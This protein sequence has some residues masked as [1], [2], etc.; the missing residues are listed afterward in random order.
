VAVVAPVE[1]LQAVGSGGWKRSIPL[2]ESPANRLVEATQLEHRG[3]AASEQG[4]QVA[5]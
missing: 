4:E 5:V 3:D 2:A 1:V